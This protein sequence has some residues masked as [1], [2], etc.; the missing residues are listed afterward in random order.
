MTCCSATASRG[1]NE[2]EVSAAC[3]T[4]GVHRSHLLHLEAP[5]QPVTVL[6][7]C[8]LG[9]AGSQRCRT[10]CQRC[11]RG[12][13]LQNSTSTS[14]DPRVDRDRL[15]LRRSVKGHYGRDLAAHSDRHRL[16]LR[17]YYAWTKLIISKAT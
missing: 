10:L 16:R 2:N 14:T 9:S 15:L 13:P 6:R 7:C 5:G 11:H 3:P 17:P 4:F 12:I 8:A 1:G